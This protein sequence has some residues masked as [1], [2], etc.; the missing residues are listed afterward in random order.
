MTQIAASD[1][2]DWYLV[3][4]KPRQE[5]TALTNLARQGYPCYLPR[6][7]V[8]KI[9]RG[10]AQVMLE[11]MF[12]RYLFVQLGTSE[13]APSWA[14][15]RSTLG[16]SQLVRFGTRPAKV[17]EKLVDLLRQREQA[18]PTE[19]LFNSGDTVVVTQ[20]PFAGLEAVYQMTD[21]QQR[22]MVLLHILSQQVAVQLD[23]ASLR[24]GG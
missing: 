1:T 24:K 21:A 4:T 6:L 5:E 3:H 19:A 20:G 14:P 10:K 17:D 15:I 7:S 13:S 12:A 2:T 8:Q 18:L 9:R 16:V 22:A 23:V 11:P